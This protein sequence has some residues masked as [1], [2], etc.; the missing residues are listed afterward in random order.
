MSLL[1]KDFEAFIFESLRNS[2]LYIGYDDTDCSYTKG[3]YS[4]ELHCDL[5]ALGSYIEKTQPITWKR[6]QKQYPGTEAASVAAEINK[7][8]P[9]RWLLE[10]L[11]NGFSLGGVGKIELVTFKPATGFNPAHRLKYEANRFTIIRQ[12]HFSKDRPND[13][14][15]LVILI[16]GLPLITMEVK[17]EFSGQT[18][19]PEEKSFL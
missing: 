13:S 3:A 4:K 15:D 18:G 2:P 5:V 8:R 1:E 12:F 14:I 19:Q 9:K 7:L 11:R 17:N 6:L 10:L 16:N